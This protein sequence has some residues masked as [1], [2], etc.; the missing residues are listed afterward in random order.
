MQIESTFSGT[1]IPKTA[2]V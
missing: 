1:L 2:L